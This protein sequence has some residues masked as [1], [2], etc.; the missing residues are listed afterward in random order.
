MNTGPDSVNAVAHQSVARIKCG[1][2]LVEKALKETSSKNGCIGTWRT[3]RASDP[4]MR[5]SVPWM[6]AWT[7]NNSDRSKKAD[8]ESVARV[9]GR[10][11][12]I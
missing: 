2:T 8:L 9:R 6:I 1:C 4:H 10:K 7:H 12:N 11:I 3:E 5:M